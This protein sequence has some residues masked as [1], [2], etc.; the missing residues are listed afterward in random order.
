M[1]WILQLHDRIFARISAML[2]GWFLPT[3]ARF[4]F[5][6]TLLMYFWKSAATKLGEGFSGLFALDPNGY[7]QIFPK[8]MEAVGYDP[9]Q[10]G[11]IYKLI[12]IAGT[13]A[14]LI[15]PLFIVLG[16]FT[17]LAALGMMGFVAVQTLVDV[18]GHGAKFGGWF[19]NQSGE[20]IADQRLFWYLLFATLLIKGAG[21]ISLDRF[22]KT[23]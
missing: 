3:F 4:I 10:L 1:T 7:V 5:A 9:S 22:C 6:A 17:R 19:N 15:L 23:P 2:A 13:W 11:F 8:A 16:L 14:E 18:T 20:L 12:A 21:P